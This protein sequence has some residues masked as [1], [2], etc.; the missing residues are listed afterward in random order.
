[1]KRKRQKS[2]I[3]TFRGSIFHSQMR[4]ET[5][6]ESRHRQTC[7]DIFMLK[8]FAS[9]CA[10]RITKTKKNGDYKNFGVF[11]QT[12][13]SN[14]RLSANRADALVIVTKAHG[15]LNCLDMN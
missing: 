7:H 6:R 9:S 4:P 8:N 13:N 12:L 14:I 3:K 10:N 5:S 2:T 1:M 15:D 11:L